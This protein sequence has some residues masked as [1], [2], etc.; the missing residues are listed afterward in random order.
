MNGIFEKATRLKLKFKTSRGLIEV[1]DLWDA[2]LTS[3]DEFNLDEIA[4]TINRKV[5]EESEESFVT[6]KTNEENLLILKLE[7]VK[8]IIEVKLNDK[9]NAARNL[10]EA[11]RKQTLLARLEEIENEGVRAMTKEEVLKELGNQ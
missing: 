4:K 3:G 11:A 7:I 10:K 9:E 1:S 5:K 2:P 8:R 6:K